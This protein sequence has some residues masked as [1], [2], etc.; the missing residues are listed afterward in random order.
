MS[1]YNLVVKSNDFL[2]SIDSKIVAIDTTD[3][4]VT[5]MPN[6]SSANDSVAAVQSGTWNVTV[7]NNI[8][9]FATSAKQDTAQTSLSSIDN[10]LVSISDRGGGGLCILAD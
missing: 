5:D 3:V 2:D 8:T 9:G 7:D 1:Q 10:N 6:L 4:T